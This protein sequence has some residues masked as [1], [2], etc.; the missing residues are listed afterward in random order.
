MTAL[1]QYERLECPGIWRPAPDAQRRDVILSFG[2]AS[3][4]I[5]DGRSEVALSHWSLPAVERLN[6]GDLPA[7]YSPGTDAAETLE[8]ED[9][10]MISALERVRAAVNQGRQRPGR[11]RTL[12]VGGTV[13]TLI[14]LGVFWLPAALTEHTADVVPLTKRIEIGRMVLADLA[15]LTGVPCRDSLGDRAAL[16]LRDRLLGQQ[17]GEI[18][19]LPRGL[20]GTAHVPGRVVLVSRSLLESHDRPEVLAGHILAE[21]L[22]ADAHDPLVDVLTH[23]G[24]R[25]TFSLLTTGNLPPESVQGYGAKMLEQP[26][27]AVTTADLLARM[28]SVGVPSTPF[29]YSLDPSGESTLALIEADPVAAAQATRI[30]LADADWVALQG[31]CGG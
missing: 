19:I 9:D 11:L 20:E 8:V 5:S 13:A 3:L 29:A 4:V 17:G 2:E 31:I 12:V 14:T 30:V 28:A 18:V 16:R 25:A 26:L 27:A 23:A 15:P 21:R 22:R 6:P 1:K 24:L 7:L 10:L